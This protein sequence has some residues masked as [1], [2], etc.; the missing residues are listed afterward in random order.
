MAGDKNLSYKVIDHVFQLA[1]IMSLIYLFSQVPAFLGQADTDIYPVLQKIMEEKACDPAKDLFVFEE[2]YL[3]DSL[4]LLSMDP[5]VLLEPPAE[6]LGLEKPEAKIDFYAGLKSIKGRLKK[7]E[8]PV[9]AL[10]RHN[11]DRTTRNKIV[12]ELKKAFNVRRCRTGEQFEIYLDSSDHFRALIWHKG[13]FD[14]Y[15]VRADYLKPESFV[16]AKRPRILEKETIKSAGVISGDLIGSF[17]DFGLDPKLARKFSDIFAS[18]IDFNTEAKLG[19]TFSLIYEKYSKDDVT[20]GY[21]RILAARY[22][23]RTGRC[24][25]AFYYD[26]LASGG[27]YTP[28]GRAL[29]SMFLK[30]PLKV[31]RIT[32]RFTSRRLH[33]ILKVYRPHYGVDLAAPIGTPIMAAADGVVKFTG[34]QRGYGRIIILEHRNGFKTYYGHLHRFARGMRKGV[35][36]HKKQIIGFVGRSGYAT[37]PHLDYRVTKNGRFINPLRMKLMAGQDL[38]GK[39]LTP[40]LSVVKRFHPLLQDPELQKTISV[41]T[42][43]IYSKPDWWIG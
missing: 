25:E 30:S 40:Y 42:E 26:K 23:S 39:E 36:V 11:I 29:G 19:D 2:P 9:A 31:Y 16:L 38:S 5:D 35:K 27:Y 14:V 37:G 28:D 22:C 4:E 43:K 6:P 1:G 17:T 13:A 18:V 24:L 15:E 3:P 32:S 34:W 41:E 21:G 7:G 8:S 33:P 20:V 12:K 10:K